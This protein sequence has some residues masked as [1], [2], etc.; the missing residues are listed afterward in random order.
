LCRIIYPD[1]KASWGQ[2]S[3][4]IGLR[5]QPQVTPWPSGGHRPAEV[6][7]HF[8]YFS[9]KIMKRKKNCIFLNYVLPSDRTLDI[10]KIGLKH[11]QLKTHARTSSDFL[12]SLLG[13]KEVR[14]VILLHWQKKST[15]AFYKLH[16][17]KAVDEE[18]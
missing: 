6:T 4:P 18:S 8:R 7:P 10:L 5:M 2:V 11:T 12:I 14:A 17:N 13:K 3:H 16:S 1:L 9:C 15:L